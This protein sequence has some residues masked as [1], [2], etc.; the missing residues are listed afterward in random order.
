VKGEQEADERHSALTGYECDRL[1]VAEGEHAETVPVA[2]RDVSQR[3]CSPL[4]DVGLAPV[5]RAEGH[6]HRRVEDDPA[7]EHALGEL[8]AHVRLARA[9]RHVP[10]DVTD[11]VLPRHVGAH[12]RQLRAPAE[13][14][15]T[16]IAGEQALH[17]AH[18]GQVERPEELIR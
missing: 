8:H 4:G 10:V 14:M 1:L 13:D 15:G 7:H 5:G 11:V 6:R 2:A 18:D 12:L 17:A 9:R 3:E 16:M